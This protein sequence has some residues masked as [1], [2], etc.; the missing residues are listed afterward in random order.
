MPTSSASRRTCAGTSTSTATTSSTDPTYPAAAARSVTP[1][2]PM[3]IL[4]DQAL[5]AGSCSIVRHGPARA[6]ALE[7]RDAGRRVDH[8]VGVLRVLGINGRGLL[9]ELGTQLIGELSGAGR[10]AGLGAELV[11]QPLAL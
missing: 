5:S 2:R 6:A 9:C 8:E 7:R 3:T 11:E 10:Q 1:T 4:T